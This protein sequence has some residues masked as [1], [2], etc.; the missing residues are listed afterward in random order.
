MSHLSRI[1]LVLNVHS[2]RLIGK[3]AGENRAGTGWD[4][5]DGS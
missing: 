4:R 5:M 1:P 3:Y 2:A